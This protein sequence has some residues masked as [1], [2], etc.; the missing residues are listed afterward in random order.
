MTNSTPTT[1]EIETAT[2]VASVTGVEALIG[3]MP[4]IYRPEFLAAVEA[5]IT[6]LITQDAL[7][8]IRSILMDIK[9]IIEAHEEDEA[10]KAEEIRA[11]EIDQICET[12][13]KYFT[14]ASGIRFDFDSALYEYLYECEISTHEVCEEF[15][16][17]PI[18]V[19]VLQSLSRSSEISGEFTAVGYL[20]PSRWNA[21]RFTAEEIAAGDACPVIIAT[22]S[23][24]DDILTP[25]IDAEIAAVISTGRYNC[26]ELGDL[27]NE[28]QALTPVASSILKGI[29]DQIRAE[30]SEEFGAIEIYEEEI[31]ALEA[32]EV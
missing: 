26:E 18:V 3:K 7:D 29:K 30:F 4:E 21:H 13:A 5:V 31:R 9:G 16:A 11:E 10:L 19:T 1:F 17:E 8:S 22:N 27:F 20:N 12:I 14:P 6:P 15:D 28:V 32:L 24:G 2:I 25:R 23:I